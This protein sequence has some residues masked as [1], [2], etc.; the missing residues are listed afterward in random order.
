MNPQCVS[1]LLHALA[2]LSPI[3]MTACRT[4]ICQT[5]GEVR[6]LSPCKLL[7]GQALAP[8]HGTLMSCPLHVQLFRRLLFHHTVPDWDCLQMQGSGGLRGAEA[9]SDLPGDLRAPHSVQQR[10]VAAAEAVREAG[11]HARPRPLR[12]HPEARRRRRDLDHRRRQKHHP[13]VHLSLGI[14]M[15]E[16][17]HGDGR[18]QCLS[19]G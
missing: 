6:A 8:Q 19:H 18:M 16:G 7:K 14:I 15:P 5:L 17:M 1:L 3:R 11:R 4:I 13:G 9:S 2:S 10:R 12:V